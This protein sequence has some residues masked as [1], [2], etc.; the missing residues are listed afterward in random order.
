MVYIFTEGNE[1]YLLKAL[2]HLIWKES[3]PDYNILPVGG[4]DNL[5]RLI[6]KF[7]ENTDQN[8]QNLIIFD[9]DYPSNHGGF[10]ARRMQ[11]LKMLASMDVAAPVF[12]L[13]NNKDDGDFEVLLEKIVLPGHKPIT[14]CFDQYVKCI[15]KLEVGHSEPISYRLPSQKSKIFALLDALHLSTKER[16]RLGKKGDWL[17]ERNDIWDLKH[18]EIQALTSFLTSNISA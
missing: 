6:E 17:F 10:E 8:G 16:E 11:I 9:A 7:R 15:Q 12:L 3:I 13:P 2:M 1:G 18:P 5:P 14:E 4:K